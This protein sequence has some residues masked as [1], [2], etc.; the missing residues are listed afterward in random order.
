[1]KEII[2]TEKSYEIILKNDVRISVS[3][4]YKNAYKNQNGYRVKRLS[5]RLLGD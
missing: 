4:S 1:V 2:Q 5:S 3:L